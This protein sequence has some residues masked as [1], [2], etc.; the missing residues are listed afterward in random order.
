MNFEALKFYLKLKGKTL[1][2]N[3]NKA[4]I[5]KLIPYQSHGDKITVAG[6]GSS[7]PI[8]AA[9]MV[10]TIAASFVLPVLS[11]KATGEP[12]FNIF[13]PYVHDQV[14][15]H[16]YFLL[17]VKNET[18]GTGFNFPVSADP[19]DVLL[20]YLYYHNGIVDSTAIN[21]VLKAAI[22][23]TESTQ[24]TVTGYLWA[25]NALNATQSSPMTQSVQVNLSSPQRLEVVPDSIKWYPNQTDIRY[26]APVALP[27]GQVGDQLF[28]SGLNI[29]NIT[30][31]WEYSGAIIF[32]LK[33]TSVQHI[34]DLSIEKT[35]RNASASQTIFAE[36]TNAKNGEDVEFQLKIQNIG[37]TTLTNLFSRDSLPTGLTYKAGSTKVDGAT[38]ADG[39]TSSGINL[40]SFS[41]G[42][43]KTITFQT[44]VSASTFGGSQTLTN[45]GFGRTDQVTEKSDTASVSV[46]Q[47]IISIAIDKR[48]KNLT[49]NQ[50]DFTD[51]VNAKPRQQLAIQI[52]V[53][54]NGNTSATNEIVR[55]LLPDRLLYITGP[56]KV[57][58]S[59]VGDGITGSGI[60]I[61]TLSAG[62]SKTITFE[63]NVDKES[64]FTRGDTTLVN[65]AYVR[66]DNISEKNDPTTILVR[67]T[68][69]ST[70]N[71][72]PGNR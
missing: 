30:G 69:C 58:G 70:E 26:D 60:N 34:N 51:T 18:K 68:G 22:T 41:A 20:F 17:D 2:Q 47:Q 40:G 46:A 48:M 1:C 55:D 24:Q 65:T 21:T 9:L 6:F 32:K 57:N 62:Q 42:A 39:L 59:A 14:Y 23:T 28:R 3:S 67:Y 66:A 45:T 53:T 33:V 36:N 64:K 61:G 7:R 15:N 25:D 5:Y 44:T 63:V 16:D 52:I 8:L 56:T 71:N 12:Q 11:S 13:T 50:T 35:V 31:C 49:E 38:I 10:F 29:G 4:N 19:G 37:N 43:T 54:N 27:F 72:R